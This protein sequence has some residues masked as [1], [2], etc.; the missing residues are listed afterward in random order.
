MSK[1]KSDAT[2]SESIEV[3]VTRAGTKVDSREA[4][5]L[6]TEAGEL[7]TVITAML[8][9]AGGMKMLLEMVKLWVEERKERRIKLKRGDIE[10]EIQGSM[11]KRE[12]QQKLELF[13]ELTKD[14]KESDIKI[15]EERPSE[16]RSP[17][18]RDGT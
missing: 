7:I 11:S 5:E 3:E 2:N 9:A 6:I 16:T 12:I 10:L 13:Q 14:A 4:G 17:S 8:S 18:L 1:Q 15:I